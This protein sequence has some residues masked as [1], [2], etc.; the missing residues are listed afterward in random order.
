MMLARFSTFRGSSCGGCRSSRDFAGRRWTML[1]DF[2]TI[3]PRPV[4]F[5]FPLIPS[6]VLLD[7]IER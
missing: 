3:G 2:N 5:H 4:S 1:G 7:G 6:P